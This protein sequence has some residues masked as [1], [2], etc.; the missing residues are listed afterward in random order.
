MMRSSTLR[1]YAE[2]M[3]AMPQPIAY[4]YR[5]ARTSHS[6]SKWLDSLRHK[7]RKVP[8]RRASVLEDMIE[9]CISARMQV[10]AAR[11]LAY[12]T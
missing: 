5:A 1:Y 8:L 2:H 9:W 6:T 10:N 11:Q 7:R 3:E 12:V 4:T